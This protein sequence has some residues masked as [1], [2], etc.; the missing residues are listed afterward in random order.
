[1]K[2]VITGGA[3]FIGCNFIH[4][5]LDNHSSDEVHCVDILTYAANIHNLEDVFDNP[6]FY[7]HKIDIRD[8]EKLDDLLC[9]IRPDLVVNFAA[10]SHVDNSIKN[11]KIFLE[12]N[13][14]GTATLMDLCL[15]Y[16]VRFHQIS[17]DEVYGDLPLD[18]QKRF[19]ESDSLNP[20]SPYASSKA[21]GDL[22]VLSYIRTYGLKA[23]ISRCTNN[24]GPYQH[25][26][27]FIPLIINRIKNQETIPIYGNGANIRNWIYVIDHCRAVDLILQKGKIGEIYNIEGN[28]E[29]SNLSLAKKILDIFEVDTKYISF[30]DDR[31]GHDLKYA[32]DDTK[33][34]EL[35]YESS[36]DFEKG[37]KMTID[38][39]N[40]EYGKKQ[41]S[42]FFK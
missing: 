6:N 12:T 15:K 40:K 13:I 18:S 34:K 41:K 14:L 22:L 32:L 37:L 1:M 31:L 36:I 19:K 38:W 3:G 30:V 10:E 23:T 8:F 5:W 33:I 42:T 29:I 4:Y 27:K 17:T 20:S 7:F 16:D 25:Q 2:L 26:E 35:G 24:Y 21:S 11:P 9:E 39:Y 28:Y